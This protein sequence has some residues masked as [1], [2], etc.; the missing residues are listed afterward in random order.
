MHATAVTKRKVQLAERAG[1]FS[2]DLSS[3]ANIIIS[4]IELTRQIVVGKYGE[5]QK[6]IIAYYLSY[7]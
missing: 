5:F 6:Q 4:A 7:G 2:S 3:I 1:A